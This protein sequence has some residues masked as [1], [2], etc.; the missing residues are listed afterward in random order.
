MKVLFI[1]LLL[2]INLILVGQDYSNRYSLGERYA[3]VIGISTYKNSANS[4][5]FAQKDA[6][7]FQNAL[8][9]YGM[10]KKENVRLLVN[11]D[12]SRENIRKNIEGWLRS[13]AN[14]NDMV[15]IFFSGHGTQIPDTDGDE[16]DGLDECLIPYD[17][18][19]QDYS[20]VICDDIFAYWVRNLQSEKILLIFD[21]CFS[22]GAAKEKGVLLS[23]VKGNIG[24]DDFIKDISRELPRKGTALLAASKADQVSFESNEF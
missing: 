11:K 17:F 9:H 19:N 7:D 20:S 4:L 10:F 22:G 12:A 6:V 21:N 23:G 13:K 18:D 15:I 16:D 3:L 1:I 8:L 14:K 24:K 5:G 2:F